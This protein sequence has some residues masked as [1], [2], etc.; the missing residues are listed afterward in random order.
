MACLVCVCVCPCKWCLQL[1]SHVFLGLY[2]DTVCTMC[3]M[4]NYVHCAHVCLFD[5]NARA[6]CQKLHILYGHT[7]TCMILSAHFIDYL[8]EAPQSPHHNTFTSWRRRPLQRGERHIAVPHSHTHTH[9]YW[10]FIEPIYGTHTCTHGRINS[11]LV[12]PSNASPK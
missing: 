7:H 4:C 2:Y 8:P 10:I 6:R 11:W 12:R 3:A 5:A 1:K 9:N